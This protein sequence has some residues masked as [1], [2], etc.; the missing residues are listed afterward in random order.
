MNSQE[1]KWQ[2]NV[3][4]IWALIGSAVG[5][6]PI[7]SFSSR[8]YFNG[9]GAFLIPLAVAVVILGFPLLVLEG[10]IGQQLQLPLVSAYG[11]TIGRFGRFLGWMAVFGVL[12]IGSYYCVITAWT[13]AYIF[14]AGMD[15]I[16][17]D[18]AVFF[19]QSFLGDSGSLTV[20][21]S[22][23]LPMIV[24]IMC[25][26]LC[27]WVVTVQSIRKGIEKFC[28]IFLPILFVLLVGFL[29]FICFLP[30]SWDGFAY[31]LT[32]Q[33]SQL[34]NPDIWLAAFGHVF[35]SFSL[36]LAIIVGY[37]RYTDKNINIAQSML[38][39]VAAEVCSSIIAGLVIF[40]GIGYMAHVQQVPF[41]NV[42]T[43]SLF[44]LGFI[45]FPKV[46]TMFPLILRIILGLIFFFCLFIAGITGLFSIVEAAAG[47]FEVE[48]SWTRYKAVTVT[49]IM[50]FF[51]A[52]LYVGGNGTYIIDALD[53]MVS[54]FNVIIAGLA[55][56]IV[57]MYF[58]PTI[59]KHAVWFSPSGKRSFTFYALKYIAPVV[60]L[61]VL[62]SSLIVEFTSSFDL[63]HSIRWAW[64]I[65]ASC[66][67]II[68]AYKK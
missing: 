25:I 53:V 66:M 58:S 67:A 60:L 26:S 42:I 30:G 11:H 10:V 46:I 65:I 44:G 51:M 39:V 41:E 43:S 9:G 22:I 61:L 48:L 59:I 50:I 20:I 33:F 57:F 29:L 31:F 8:C 16:P 34:L 36:A 19:T 37:S 32:P 5:F 38:W 12:S 23:S 62:I 1:N 18:T 40:G 45:V 35:F 21:K 54:G 56:I 6:G 63:A 47:N 14:Y 24:S 28:S 64:F 68:C 2:S 15:M 52:L 7:L 3:G 27:T 49:T 17:A 55:E 4:Y 13:I